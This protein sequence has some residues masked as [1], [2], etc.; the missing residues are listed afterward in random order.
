MPL[1]LRTDALCSVA[2]VRRWGV[3]DPHMSA[4]ELDD[5]LVEAINVATERILSVVRGPIVQTNYVLQPHNGTGTRFL[6]LYYGP[7]V[8]VTEV[9]IASGGASSTLDAAAYTVAASRGALI[10]AD[11]VWPLGSQNVLVSYSAGYAQIPWAVR[12]ACARLALSMAMDRGRDPR[13]VRES[14]PS[15]LVDRTAV[16]PMTGL[17]S[18]VLDMLRPYRWMAISDGGGP[19]EATV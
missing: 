13:V 19:A 12:R 9:R 11:T 16:D 18:D 5:V 17:P 8:A 4:T 6:Y 15:M 10:R 7:V 14:G 1:S 2:D 3:F